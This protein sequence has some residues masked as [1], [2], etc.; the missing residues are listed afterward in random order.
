MNGKIARKN[1]DERY[2]SNASGV[3]VLESDVPIIVKVY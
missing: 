2:A 1:L 3:A